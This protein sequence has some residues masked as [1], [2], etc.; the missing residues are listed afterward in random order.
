MRYKLLCV[1]VDGTLV[2]SNKELPIENKKAIQ[3]AFKAGINIAI[4]SGRSPGSVQEILDEL[5]VEGYG[6]CLNGSYIKHDNKEISRFVF[7]KNEIYKVCEIVKKYDV[8]A[9]FSTPFL[10]I[11]NKTPSANWLKAIQKSVVRQKELIVCN[12]ENLEEVLEEYSEIILKV[13]IME[14][15]SDT[16]N[17]IKKDLEATGIFDVAK[18]D[19]HYVD[20]NVKGINKSKGVKDLA[21]YLNI[22]LSEVI[23]IGDNEN[24]IDMIKIAGLGVAMKN[25]CKKLLEICDE[26]T[27]SNDDFGVAKV[28][29]DYLLKR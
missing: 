28:I 20:V 19:N 27:S 1:D 21:E 3:E 26:V 29:Y 6:I 17:K 24:D 23:C 25:S 13:S 7:N 15:N 5:E 11:T 2:N 4:A 18:S 9:F 10:N 8:K 22:D 12:N 16:Y 14:E